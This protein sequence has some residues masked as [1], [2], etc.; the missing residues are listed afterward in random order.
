VSIRASVDAWLERFLRRDASLAAPESTMGGQLER[1]KRNS[2]DSK[3][4]KFVR[5]KVRPALNTIACRACTGAGCSACEGTG[6]TTER[7]GDEI[8]EYLICKD[9]SAAH[10]AAHRADAM[11][12]DHGVDLMV[13]ASLTPLGRQI[14]TLQ[15]EPVMCPGRYQPPQHLRDFDKSSCA[16]ELVRPMTEVTRVG[17]CDTCSAVFELDEQGKPVAQLVCRV[18]GLSERI[19]QGVDRRGRAKPMVLSHVRRVRVKVQR[20]LSERRDGDGSE[21]I[22]PLELDE[23]GFAWMWHYELVRRGPEDIA[24]ELGITERQLRSCVTAARKQIAAKLGDEDAALETRALAPSGAPNEEE[25]RIATLG[26]ASV[27]VGDELTRLLVRWGLAHWERFE[28]VDGC[29]S[30]RLAR[31]YR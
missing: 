14:L 15:R 20:R 7:F 5:H 29:D 27:V 2:T 21:L 25:M 11:F 4:R 18:C 13:W 28:D 26:R 24:A 16:H 1:L 8:V 31:T 10:N 19:A 22:R 12:A 3:G 30:H 9:D 6:K 17:A 23:Q